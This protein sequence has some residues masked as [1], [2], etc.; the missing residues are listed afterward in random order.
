MKPGQ[1]V[2]VKSMPASAARV[3]RS[4]PSGSLSIEL[5]KAHGPYSKGDRLSVMP[6]E[7]IRLEG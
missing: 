4:N 5:T 6:Y 3:I 2:T 1:R 7:V